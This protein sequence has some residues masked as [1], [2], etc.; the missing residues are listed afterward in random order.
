MKG[1]IFW[2]MFTVAAV[3]AFFSMLPD[4]KRYMKMRC[5]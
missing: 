5:M 3:G 4:L 2:G 1:K